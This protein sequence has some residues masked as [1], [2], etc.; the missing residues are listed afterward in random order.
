[1]T[2][3]Q[4]CGFEVETKMNQSLGQTASKTELIFLIEK[5]VQYKS[6]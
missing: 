2:K 5:V 4:P 1:M 6:E 3:N